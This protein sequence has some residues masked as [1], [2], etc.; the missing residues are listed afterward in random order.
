MQI[1]VIASINEQ[2]FPFR[3]DMYLE[4]SLFS[5]LVNRFIMLIMVY[6][7]IDIALCCSYWIN[8]SFLSFSSFKLTTASVSWSLGIL[9]MK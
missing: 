1:Y 4:A 2:Y 3:Y 5:C 7:H 6:V 8:L 9:E